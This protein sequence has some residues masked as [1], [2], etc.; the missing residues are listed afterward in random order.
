ML[1]ALYTLLG[2]IAFAV[3]HSL[4]VIVP[5]K[6]W[7]ATVCGQH[8]YHGLYRLLYNVISGITF[9]PV[10]A[11][12]ALRPGP[13]VWDVTGLL[14]DLLLGGQA[15]SL[16]ALAVAG[17]QIDTLRFA[18]LRQAWAYLNGDPLPLPPEA[19][20]TG[21]VYGL[22]RH[23]LYL[24]VMLFLWANPTMR[25]A[26]LAFAAG[27]S[28]YFILGAWIEERRMLRRLGDTY[29]AYQCRVPFLIPF[30]RLPDPRCQEA[31]APA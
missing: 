16:I 8:A 2:L 18:G 9:L 5:F 28:A 1:A 23:P 27:A 19:L 13:I 4:M 29:R 20:Q 24:F 30:V 31:D 15:F 3:L 7:F 17:L 11:L 21:G 26:S 10:L 14:R 22:V 12:I 6:A 25:T